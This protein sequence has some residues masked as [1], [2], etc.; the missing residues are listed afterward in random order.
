MSHTTNIDK[1]IHAADQ[2]TEYLNTDANNRYDREYQRNVVR[3]ARDALLEINDSLPG[4]SPEDWEISST[5]WVA[6]AKRGDY[7]VVYNCPGR[8][9]VE[10]MSGTH[11]WDCID[12]AEIIGEPARNEIISAVKQHRGR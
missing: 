6:D 7:A 12:A 5:E 8:L 1:I 10:W 9:T 4:G 11:S 3:D 2:V